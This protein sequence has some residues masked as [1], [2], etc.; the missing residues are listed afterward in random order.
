MINFSCIS[1]KVTSR[2]G[3]V[4]MQSVTERHQWKKFLL[5]PQKCRHC[6]KQQR[7]HHHHQ[8]CQQSYD[9]HLERGLRFST[10]L[11]FFLCRDVKEG[12]LLYGHIQH[13][14]MVYNLALLLQTVK[15]F[16]ICGKRKSFGTLHQKPT[17]FLCETDTEKN[18]FAL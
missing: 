17:V 16:C 7:H 9:G 10:A 2:W 3:R 14:I 1:H 11:V 15:V 4:M 18:K 5:N 13:H 12:F 8:H 6:Q